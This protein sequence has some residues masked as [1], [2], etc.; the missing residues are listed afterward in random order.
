MRWK[1][2]LSNE[3]TNSPKKKRTKQ[4]NMEFFF[5]VCHFLDSDVEEAES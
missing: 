1:D 2:T 5:L 4:A 3:I